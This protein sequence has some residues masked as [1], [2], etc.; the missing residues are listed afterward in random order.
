MSH[1]RGRLAAAIGIAAALLVSACSNNGSS[2][3]NSPSGSGSTGPVAGGNLTIDT[4]TPPVDF[5]TNTTVDN[6]SIWILEQVAE[7]L[8]SNGPDGKSLTPTLATGYTVSS[9]KTKWT[10]TLRQGVKFSNGKPMTA[11]D[12]VFSL[13]AARN[14][15]D[16][17]SFVDTAIKSVTAPDG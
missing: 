11:N 14:P 3:S 7:P 9:D 15:K 6:E 13:N 16:V 5:N 12:V 2:S 8:Y 4:L 17:F 1:P 10:F